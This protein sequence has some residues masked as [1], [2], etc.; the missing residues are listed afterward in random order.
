MKINYKMTLLLIGSVILF[1]CQQQEA[2]EPKEPT[3]SVE[4]QTVAKEKDPEPAYQ[5]DPPKPHMQKKY[6]R[7]LGK[8]AKFRLTTDLTHLS[9]S[10]KK[11]LYV[12]IDAAKIMDELFWLQSYGSKEPFLD[13]IEDQSLRK[14][15]EINYGPWDRLDGDQ[16][17]LEGYV[18]KFLGANFYPKDL[19]K[20]EFEKNATEAMKGLYTNVVAEENGEL[21]AVPFHVAYAEQL[22]KAAA[23]L[24]EAAS[25][26]ED[27]GFKKY[28]ELRAKALLDDDYKASDLAWMDMKTNKIDVVIGPIETYED[29]LFG[30][31]AAYEAYVLVK[32][33][34]WSEKLAKFAAFLPQLQAE[35]PVE[36]AYK[37]ETPG[38]D[39]DLNAYD[40]IYYA[41]HSNA[42]SKTIAINLPNDESVQLEKG[43]RRLQLK[44]VMRA[45][46]EKILMPIAEELVVP[47]Q[48]KHITF[49][50][51]FANTMFHEVAH[52]LGVKNTINDKGMVRTALKEYA[53]AIEEGKADILGLYMVEK[54]HKMGELD[55][56]EMMDYYTTFMAGIF[57][58]VRFGSSSAHGV[59]N[60][61]RFNYFSEN[62]AFNF[63]AE[64]GHYAVN[65]EKM[66]AAVASL[67]EKIL[68]LQGNGDYQ[69]VAKWFK[70]K[71]EINKELANALDRINNKGIPVDIDFEQGAKYLAF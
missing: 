22:S 59:A 21:K 29:Q 61:L 25:L 6:E 65:P 16:P 40:A 54:L 5:Q 18:G 55:E 8:Y 35:L 47:E 66:S 38:T 63:N 41:G 69:G 32:D 57:R 15:A 7:L 71:G 53:S 17:F 68:T 34:G 58:S 2:E 1:G 4:K 33:L 10:Q 11:M 31:K 26:A 42:G 70:E 52:G 9:D 28:L 45:K 46:F 62:G 48:R 50:A 60:L 13:S 39:S 24:N 36:A 23:L 3:K 20:G 67:S 49:N 43:T 30:Y 19:D 37:T 27:E 12:L 44:N 51:F 14:F 64:T 56:G